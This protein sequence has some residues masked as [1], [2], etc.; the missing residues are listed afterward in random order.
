MCQFVASVARCPKQLGGI[1]A[2]TAGVG[3]AGTLVGH[4]CGYPAAKIVADYGLLVFTLFV[5]LCCGLAA[6]SAEGRQRV[7]WI[8]LTVGSAGWAGG[9]AVW[10]LYER[11]LHQSPF[12]SLAD[13]GYLW[14]PVGA[15]LAMVL[16][17]IGY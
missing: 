8:C 1:G 10:I 16:F 12:P 5:A 14:F 4:G 17:P 3:F 11:V 15:G 6:W 7:A 13:V 2:V 9:E